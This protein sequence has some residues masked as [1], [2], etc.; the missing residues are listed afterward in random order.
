LL[1]VT[2]PNLEAVSRK[3][4]RRLHDL[5]LRLDEAERSQVASVQAV[6]GEI[7]VAVNDAATEATRAVHVLL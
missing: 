3:T 2:V 1:E 4:I 6:L 7:D 5:L